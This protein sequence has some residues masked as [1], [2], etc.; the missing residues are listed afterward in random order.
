LRKKRGAVAFEMAEIERGY[1]SYTH[2]SAFDLDADWRDFNFTLDALRALMRPVAG[3]EL[4]CEGALHYHIER[5]ALALYDFGSPGAVKL[6]FNPS[7]SD[8]SEELQN[9]TAQIEAQHRCRIERLTHAHAASSAKDDAHAELVPQS[10]TLTYAGD[11]GYKKRVRIEQP[12]LACV[13][14]VLALSE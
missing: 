14:H 9:S 2:V 12:L 8:Y 6:V 13:E 10:A 4:R 1:A 11:D 5:A 3:S 7:L